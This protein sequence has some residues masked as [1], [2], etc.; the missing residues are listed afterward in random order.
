MNEDANTTTR[1]Q[2]RFVRWQDALRQ[3]LSAHVALIVA[4]ASG[5][6]GFVGST[7]NDNEARFGGFTS[8]FILG[9]G[10]LFLLSLFA[11]LFL[12]CN[13]LQDVRATLDILKHR[14]DESPQHT[15][16]V[17]QKRTDTLGERTWCALY[18]QLGLFVAAAVFF[19]GRCF[20]GLRAQIIPLA[21]RR[22][23]K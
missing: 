11:A 19:F 9:A 13:R 20:S 7:L 4:L 18:W 12:S 3:T 5:G 17:L 22:R 10:V 21:N 14:R 2:E 1:L 6:L 15:I 23:S 16:E 8:F